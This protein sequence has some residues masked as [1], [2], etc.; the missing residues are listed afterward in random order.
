MSKTPLCSRCGARHYNFDDC[1]SGVGSFLAPLP[2]GFRE[3]KDPAPSG[4]TTPVP[5]GH[6][7]WGDVVPFSQ[8][9]RP[10][11]DGPKAA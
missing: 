6:K 8:W 2:D 11:D 3:W 4:L 10:E 1:P 7:V 5:P 9:K